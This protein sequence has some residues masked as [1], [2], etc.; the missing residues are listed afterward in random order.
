MLL[1]CLASAAA[2]YYTGGEFSLNKQTLPVLIAV[3]A[4][5]PFL[6]K[7]L[8]AITGR[9]S[10]GMRSAGLLL[11][12]FDGNPPARRRRFQRMFGSF[13]SL[14]AVGVGVVWPLFDEDRLTWHDHISG[15]FPTIQE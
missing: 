15:T 3:L 5:V 4:T 11:V 2:F 1:P 7:F 9:D 14:L 6:Y 12:D 8:W 13:L 10:I